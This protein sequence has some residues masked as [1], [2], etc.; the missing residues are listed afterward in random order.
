M[1]DGRMKVTYLKELLEKE[2]YQELLDKLLQ[3]EKQR[4]SS[5]SSL[6]RAEWAYYKNKLYITQSRPITTLGK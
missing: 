6:A 1:M 5:V 4:E 3:V 2:Q